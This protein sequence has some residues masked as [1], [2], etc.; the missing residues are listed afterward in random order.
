MSIIKIADCGKG[1]NTDAMPEELNDG[2]WSN[3]QNMRFRTGFAQ[4]F[5]GLT[6]VHTT[7]SIT[8]YYIAPY[9]TATKRYWCHA[10]NQ[11]VFVHDGTTQT[12]ITPAGLFTGAQDDRW[13]GGTLSG[14]LVLNNGIDQPQFWAGNVANDLA[15]LTGWNSNWRCASMRP[16]KNYLIAFDITKSGTRYPHM[17]KWSHVAI[18]G[19]VPTSWDETDVTKD[20]GEQ[21]LAETPDLLVDALPMGDVMIVYKE[22]SM[23]SMSFIGAPYIWRFQKL[24]GDS[25]MLTRGCAVNT[26]LGHVVLTSGDVVIHQAQGVNSICDGLI[27]QFI[28]NNIDSTNYK[29]AFVTANPQKNEVMVCFPMNGSTYCDK[30]A[31]WNWV[32]KT[33]GLRDLPNVTYGAF[34]QVDFASTPGTWDA[35][36]ETWD[37]DATEWNSNEYAPNEA[38]LMLSTAVPYIVA[39]DTGST[40]LGVPYR[41][42]LERQQMTFGDAFKT[43]LVRAVYPRIN[44]ADGTEIRIEVGGSM[45]PDDSPIWSTATTFIV[46]STHKA[47]VFVTGRFISLR[48]TST[49]SA[50]WRVRSIDLDI[51]ISGDY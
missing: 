45:N 38:R 44:A 23:Y 14:I 5:R 24:P 32:D 2:M 41:S 20:A 33:W 9:Q 26:P 49:S 51:V 11:K 30:A 39:F 36:T 37:S 50:E 7:P 6:A 34:G 21:D 12:E 47:D 8:P 18:P 13:S 42:M 4:R 29:R 40:D 15:N 19:A 25:G 35:D 1:V 17:V 46:G 48:L 31:V 27:R 28:F 22:R 16:F 10:G 3:C 43:K